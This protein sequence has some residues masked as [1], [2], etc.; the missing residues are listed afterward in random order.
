VGEGAVDEQTTRALA[1]ELSGN[2]LDIG[3][4]VETVLR[5]SVFFAPKNLGSRVRGPVEFVIG[6]CRALVPGQ[7]MP[8]TLLLADWTARL[9]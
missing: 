6:A 4:A 1:D 7:S 3:R 9:G 8:S 5:S 2:R